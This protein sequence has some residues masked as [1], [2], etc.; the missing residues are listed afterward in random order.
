MKA[1][2]IEYIRH[3]LG[4]GHYT[5]TRAEAAQALARQG[6]ALDKILQRLKHSGW[7]LSIGDGFF[8]IIDP[9]HQGIGSIPISWF[10]EA[11]AKFKGLEYY[12]G[13][14]SAAEAHGAAHQRP[15]SFQIV[16]NRN[17]RP[18][19]IP[20]IN[21]VFLYKKRIVS[22]M[23]G[24]HK[25]PT[26]V[27]RV[28]TPE[29]TAYDL[30][31]LRKACP[32]IDHVATI[33]KELGEVMRA[34]GLMKLFDFRCETAI[35]QRLGWLLDFT[36]W[37]KLTGKLSTKLKTGRLNWVLLQP[38]LAGLGSRNE[39]WRIIENTDVQSDL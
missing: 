6:S 33:Y 14:L 21:I 9:L 25:V 7:L 1:I 3:L 8:V 5:F 34:D 18:F 24:Q 20:S 15:Q 10:L 30:L 35:L 2:G 38:G 17:M 13:G 11:W 22:E 4:I 12:V 31:T 16:V 26:G 27:Y 28:S 19:R 23:W 32:S 36:G 39:K 37:A 29:L